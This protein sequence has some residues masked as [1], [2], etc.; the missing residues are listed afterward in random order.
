MLLD[1]LLKGD[2]W[3]IVFNIA[4]GMH[5]FGREALVPALLDAYEIPYTFSDPLTLSTTLHKPTAKR[6]VRDH[7]IPTPEFSVVHHM[8]DIERVE[9]AYPLFA[10]PVAE[11]TSKGIDRTSKVASRV[12]L[13]AVCERLLK[14]Y[15]Q[16]VL[17]EQFM[18][19]REFTVG[20]IGTGQAARALGVMEILLK[21]RAEPEIYTFTNKRQFQE[22]VGFRLASD[23][24]AEAAGR[25]ALDAWSALGSRDAGRVDLRCDADGRVFFLEANPLAGLHPTDS[26]LVIL[27]RLLGMSYARLIALILSSAVERMKLS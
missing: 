13:S 8:R 12:E 11:G 5:G 14:A 26:D 18:P 20:I 24:V 19:G 1:R 17:V 10:K 22:R 2:R 7:G 6:I 21:E 23:A 16:P 15:R 4:E 3:D 25:V 27:A 9:L